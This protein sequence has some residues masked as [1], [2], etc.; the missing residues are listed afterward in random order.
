MIK[1]VVGASSLEEFSAIQQRQ[2]M[3]Y[4][5]EPAVP[6]WT[7]FKP[8]RG[9]EIL[10]H[11]GSLY[12]VIQG[13]IQCRQRILGYEMIDT[14]QG[15]KCMIMQDP[16]I[17]T[18]IKMSHR[19]FQGWRYLDPAKAPADSGIYHS[20]SNDTPPDDMAESLRAAGLLV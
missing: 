16:Q 12:R 20:G 3:D 6:C 10:R 17:I 11:G 2:I 14:D 13:R 18:T 1:L 5:G 8:K 7:R 19:P 15:K 4:H 9:D